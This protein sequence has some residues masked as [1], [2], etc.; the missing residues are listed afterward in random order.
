M[1]WNR[2]DEDGGSRQIGMNDRHAEVAS[3]ASDVRDIVLPF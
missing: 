1:W 3:D 2:V